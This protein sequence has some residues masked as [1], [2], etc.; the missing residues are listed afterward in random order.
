MAPRLRIFL[1]SP[2]DVG[3]ERLRA[4]LVI[5]KLARDY[6]R[7]FKIEPFLWEYEPQL[8]SKHFQDLVDPPSRFDIV[9]LFVWSRL[10]TPL[11]EKTELREYRGIDGRGP[12][13]G[14]EWEFEDALQANR[15]HGGKGPPD[16]LVYRRQVKFWSTNKKLH[17]LGREI[18]R[19][20]SCIERFRRC[21][22][23][24]LR[25]SMRR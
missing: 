21:F 13:T 11:P 14:T 16:L 25:R 8:A 22:H 24:C 7:Y 15:A 17:S 3:E 5:E 10:G 18:S 6:Q 20:Q 12:V 1:S 9:L 23:S 2:G 19:R 4:H